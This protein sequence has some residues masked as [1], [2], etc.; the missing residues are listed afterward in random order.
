MISGR[1]VSV[2]KKDKA[3]GMG[4]RPDETLRQRII[5]SAWELFY[6]KGYANTTIKEI[7]EKAGTSKGGFYYY[8]SQKDDLLNSLYVVFDR[9]YEKF[10]S[11]LDKSQNAILQLDLVNQYVCFFIDANVS[12]ELLTEL[13]RSQLDRRKQEAFLDPNR[14]YFRMVREIIET[15]QKRGEIRDDIDASTLSQHILLLERG[16]LINWCVRAGSYSL[17]GKGNEDFRLYIAFLKPESK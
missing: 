14:Y 11:S 6:E 10:Y 3:K 16:I 12:Y 4:K 9:E 15:G 1:K 7:I 17:G 2:S 13:Y 8:F 5:D